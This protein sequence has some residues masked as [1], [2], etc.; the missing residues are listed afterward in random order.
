MFLSTH[1]FHGTSVSGLNPGTVL[2]RILPSS[3]GCFGSVLS[4]TETK[5][6]WS[7]PRGKPKEP[8][9]AFCCS[10]LTQS[11]SLSHVVTAD[12]WHGPVL[13][14]QRAQ[15]KTFK[16]RVSYMQVSHLLPVYCPLLVS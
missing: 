10:S 11:V 16:I 8:P 9:L 13:A 15:R 2:W 5:P 7:H 6:K 4:N 12:H 3:T 1:V 14:Y